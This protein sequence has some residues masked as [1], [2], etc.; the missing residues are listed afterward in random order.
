MSE[1]ARGTRTGSV[2]THALLV[3]GAVAM[4]G[5]FGWQLLTAFKSLPE[6]TTVPPSVLPREWLWSNFAEVFELLPFGQQLLNSLVVAA[7]VTL[8]QLAFCSLGAYAFARLEFRGRELI[9][10][11][12]LSVLMVPKQLLI[13]PQYQIMSGLGLLNSLPALILPGLFS[14]FGTFLLR[15]FFATIPKDFEEAALLDGAGRF[16]IFFSIMLPLVK[17][18]LAALAVITVMHSWNDLL[19]PL[20]VNT[21]PASM[22]IS[23]GLTSLQG[24][25]WTDYPVLMA[26]AL[27]ASIPMLLAYLA[28]Q[29]QFVQGIALSGTKG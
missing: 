5:P 19:W 27:M 12:F 24:Q 25:E 10:A 3:L 9:F 29:R 17:P 18:A 8:G 11:L 13:L 1:S 4:I 23:A 14:A 22:P 28:L 15:Q 26:G 7:A 6:T 21:A 2:L 20:V 16:R